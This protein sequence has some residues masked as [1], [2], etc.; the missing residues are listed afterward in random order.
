MVVKKQIKT[1]QKSLPKTGGREEKMTCAFN[2]FSCHPKALKSLLMALDPY[3]AASLL[4]AWT[5]SKG[6]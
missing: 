3:A 6:L 2:Y 1:K 4:P 5:S